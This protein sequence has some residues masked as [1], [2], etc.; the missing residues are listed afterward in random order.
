MEKE[1]L[2]FNIQALATKVARANNQVV[3]EK[4]DNYITLYQLEKILMVFNTSE[5]FEDEY[6]MT[7]E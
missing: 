5:P 2:Y 3:G 6:I 1:E 4:N 7:Y